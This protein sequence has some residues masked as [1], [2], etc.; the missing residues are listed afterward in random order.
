MPL[1]NVEGLGPIEFADDMTEEQ[2]R[3][4]IEKDILPQFPELAAQ[5]K[6][7]FGEATTDVVASLGKGVASLGQL[8]GQ[9]GELAGLFRPEERDVGI[10]GQARKLEKFAEEQ[11]SPTL[12]AREELRSRKIAESEGFFDEL[13]TSVM[14]TIKD[15]ALVSSF[16]FEQVPN[17][18]ATGG[19]GALSKVGVKAL[20]AESTAAALGKAGV[21]EYLGK[22]GVRTAIG[23][24]AVMQGADIGADTFETIYTRLR[25]EGV[26]EDKALEIA[27]SKGRIAAIEAAGLSL[28][29]SKLPGGASIERAMLGKGL[30]GAGGFLRGTLGEAFSEAVEEGGGAIAK[31]IGVQ[32]VFPEESLLK[33]VG[34]ATGMGALGGALFGAP[35]GVMTGIQQRQIEKYRDLIEQAKRKAQEEQK[36]VPLM[37]PYD[38]SV[39]STTYGGTPILVNPDGTTTF[40]A[41]TEASDEALAEKYAPKI[42][43][44]QR[45][46]AYASEE[47]RKRVEDARWAEARKNSPALQKLDAI[48]SK[49][50][51]A[52]DQ[53]KAD[54]SAFAGAEP[55]GGVFR[56]PTPE[57]T[58]AEQQKTASYQNYRTIAVNTKDGVKVFEGTISGNSARVVDQN[59]KPLTFNINSK[60]VIVDPSERDIYDIETKQ[61]EREVIKAEVDL[62][63]AKQVLKKKDEDFLAF[64]RAN[65]IDEENSNEVIDGIR[66]W[67]KDR[68]GYRALSPSES[69][70]IFKPGTNRGLDQLAQ[71]AVERGFISKAE[72]ENPNDLYGTNALRLK[73]NQLFMGESPKTE[74]NLNE[75]SK[76]E[77]LGNYSSELFNEIER[78]KELLGN[79]PTAEDI[80]TESDV[81]LEGEFDRYLDDN[82]DR[83][84][85][86][87]QQLNSYFPNLENLSQEERAEYDEAYDALKQK[88]QNEFDESKAKGK[89]F[90]VPQTPYAD[91]FLAD[92]DNLAKEL[93]AAL[94]KMGLSEVALN[95][96]DTLSQIKDGKPT[97]VNGTY[98]QK[99]IELSLSGDNIFRTLNHESLHAMRELGFFTDAQWKVLSE[100]AEKVWIKKYNIDKRYKD[101]SQEEKIEEAVADAFGDMQTQPANIKS[102][103]AKM[104][105]FLKRIGNVLRGRG[106]N[107]AEDILQKAAEG[108][109]AKGKTKAGAEKRADRVDNFKKWFGN[110]K[111]VDEDGNPLVVYHGTARDFSQFDIKNLGDNTRTESGELGF[112][113]TSKPFLADGYA[114]IA[115][116]GGWAGKTE[117]G[118]PIVYPMYIKIENPKFYKT[119]TDFYREAELHKGRLNE[120][121][122]ELQR[123]GF[124]GV[125][126]R[127]DFEE[128]IAFKPTQ[129]K[130]ATGNRGEYSTTDADIRAERKAEVPFEENLRAPMKD[131][132]EDFA[133]KIR[134]QFAQKRRTVKQKFD[135]L[136]PNMAERLIKGLFDEFKTIERYDPEAYMLARMSKS[137][138]GALEGLLM[139]GQVFLRDGAID[140]KPNTKGLL[141]ILEPL[142][143]EVDQYQIW[144]ALNRDANL[145]A[146]KR[147]FKDLIG[148]RNQLIRGE[149]NGKP[150]KEVYEQALKEENALNKSVLDLALEQGLIDQD[151]Y[152]TFSNDI[153]YIPFYKAVEDGKVSGMQGASKLTNQY[154]SKALKGGDKKTNDLMENVLMNWSHILSASMKNK[155]AVK[156]L[157]AAVEMGAAEKVSSTYEGKDVVK[158][159]VDGKQAYYAVNDPDLIDS[160]SLISYLGPKSPFLDVARGFTN[161]L[162]YGITLSP[163]YKVRNLIRDSIQSAAVSGVG[164]NI[165][166]NVQKGMALSDEGNPTFISALASGG[167]FEMGVAHEG[168]QAKLIKRLVDKGVSQGTILDS[169]EKIK[170]GL[171]K[172]L[173]WYNRQGNRFE[174]ANRLALYDKLI[175]EGK[176]HLE[177]SYAAR[178]LMDFSLQGS[179]RAL[180][181]VS[182]LVPFFNARLQGLYKLGRDGISPT[183][184][185]LYNMTTGEEIDATD[186]QKAQ[187]FMVVSSAVMLASM[188]LYMAYKD[189]EDFQRREGWDRD[190]FWWFKAGDTI[191]R[192]PKPFEIGALGTIAERS[193][194]QIMD[195]NV[196]GK[197]FA[198]RLHAILMDTFA[199]NPTPQ[200]AKPL[201]DLYA[202]KDS[203]TGAPIETAGMERLSKQERYTDTTSAL[204]KAL[205]GVSQVGSKI[206]TFNPQAEG[207]SPVQFDYAI[208]AYLGWAGA[209]AASVSDKAVQPWSEVEKPGKPLVDT[210]AMGFVKTMPETQSKFVSDFYDNSTRINQ[211]FADMKRY[212]EL[213]EMDKVAKIL[214]EKGDDLR[215]QKI[216]DSTT[217]Q[218]AMYRKHI[219]ILTNDKE[220]N[221]A[222]KRNEIA[223]MKILISEASKNAENIRKELKRQQ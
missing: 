203:F 194:E 46:E 34:A 27:L 184:R 28:A 43:E 171:Q 112:F 75:Y 180:K 126:V 173:E 204:A 96:E 101:L 146:E 216:Y 83:F 210:L 84:V 102:I 21:Q 165:I 13:G 107:T 143:T 121:R 141:K 131:V 103:F 92:L 94:N 168:D 123:Q 198:Q 125:I 25:A 99:L 3:N 115:S 195:E 221:K 93:R 72:F 145:P 161:A 49:K 6:R 14:E 134:G 152:K 208:K 64:L 78:R 9:V 111:V 45:T 15:P 71:I 95:L 220:M 104:K 58:L 44:R 19:A 100:T 197:V 77:Q 188:L 128:V 140:I 20:M 172:A 127:G 213:G 151:A 16:F 66:K 108:K 62:N 37:L 160:I 132:D 89:K 120:W 55:V 56:A 153:Y 190:N 53:K 178:D 202:N 50:V 177:A 169:P 170:A 187:R 81:E 212:A 57:E 8:P 181:V 116:L 222:D 189:D 31:N 7:T 122:K 52:E 10:Q 186:K 41:V 80:A 74:A 215:L 148:D 199:M 179:F 26:P 85:A 98:F 70:G 35:A 11:K 1:I 139:Y 209:T 223:R 136:R 164:M 109:L 42:P 12:K 133:N 18:I 33:G 63:K 73:I 162:R 38:P 105:D 67:R 137:V 147:S 61:L 17:F 76:F 4:A 205:G 207:I 218:I 36:A 175:A 183:Y 68:K 124:D 154:F 91:K 163:A 40:P 158:V 144:K 88:Y 193:L 129:I 30:P 90:E 176:T 149:L 166:D 200:F 97:T 65:P 110:S 174:N 192:V 156:T 157:D 60:N 106:F 159:M 5:R 214:E 32:Q 150:R 47:D 191:F 185:V 211:V 201:I 206:L 217:K 2:I 138:D 79:V 29:S 135:D 23:T 114:E 142:G 22:V 155:A 113:F 196:E 69:K 51:S 182:Q 118:N 54:E 117:K 86:D 219:Q 39:G 59:G 119:A 82:A 87:L 167:I 130:S 24:G 48:K